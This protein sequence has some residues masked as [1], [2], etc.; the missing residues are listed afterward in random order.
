MLGI[1][2]AFGLD[3]SWDRHMASVH[4]R[5]HLRAIASDLEQNAGQLRALIAMEDRVSANSLAL[6]GLARSGAAV[7]GDSIFGLLGMVFNSRRYEPVTGA[8]QALINSAGLTLIRD[9]SLRAALAGFSSNVND[10]YYEYFS[11]ELYLAFI[12]DFSTQAPFF[13]DALLK[14]RNSTAYAALMHDARFQEHLALR[15]VAERDVARHYRELLAQAE[16]ILQ[17]IGARQN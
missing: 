6:L 11:N 8:Y 3:A 7:P 13:S 1:L 17:R 2:I 5:E 9:D 10:R 14:S 12:R 16:D 15:H 4:E